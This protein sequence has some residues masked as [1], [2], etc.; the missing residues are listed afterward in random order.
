MKMDEITFNMNHQHVQIGLASSKT[1]MI[2]MLRAIWNGSIKH[3]DERSSQTLSRAK[4]S[5]SFIICTQVF[6]LSF[7]NIYAPESDEGWSFINGS[8]A[9]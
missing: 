9:K 4:F 3:Y 7:T 6:D 2:K 5:L 1:Y 8:N